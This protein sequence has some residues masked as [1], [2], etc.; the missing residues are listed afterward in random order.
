M[1]RFRRTRARAFI[2]TAIAFLIIAAL[3]PVG[4]FWHES[5]QSRTVDRFLKRAD[6]LQEEGKDLEAISFLD[7]YLHINRN[8]MEV[9]VRLVHAVD[10]VANNPLRKIRAME[11]YRETWNLDRNRVELGERCADLEIE[12][13]RYDEALNTSA[14]LAAINLS[15]AEPTPQGQAE[16]ARR[17]NEARRT[18]ARLKALALLGRSMRADVVTPEDE[19]QKI[20]A[21]FQ[22]AI[23]QNPKDIELAVRLADIERHQLKSAPAKERQ[24][25]ADGLM[26]SMVERNRERPEAFLARYLYWKSLTAAAEPV[27]TGSDADLDRALEIG[28][29]DPKRERRR[30]VVRRRTCRGQERSACRSPVF[31]ASHGGSTDRLSRLGSPGSARCRGR[32]RRRPIP[33]G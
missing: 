11:L 16:A 10:K 15:P 29:K 14:E 5:Q 13:A 23:R 7:R 22:E 24:K 2:Q 32:D 26:D 21:A 25:V 1:L 12:L 33:S 3:V 28:H 18:A 30:A 6:K 27:S 17:T 19:W 9:R 31:R 20:V 8:D 4:Y